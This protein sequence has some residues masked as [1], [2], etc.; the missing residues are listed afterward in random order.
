MSLPTHIQKT[1]SD[2]AQTA[3]SEGAALPW[4]IAETWNIALG[5][6]DFYIQSK[7]KHAGRPLREPIPNC[8]AIRTNCKHLFQIC[9]A[10]YQSGHL[11]KLLR[12]SVIPFLALDEYR[13]ILRRAVAKSTQY[14]REHLRTLELIEN[15]IVTQQE[16]IKVMRQYE[17]ALAQKINLTLKIF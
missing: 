4:A 15:L 16:Q 2:T 5:R 6:A 17:Q 1:V 3:A 9:F 7:G 13:P 14:D 12:G 11:K 10:I 8:W